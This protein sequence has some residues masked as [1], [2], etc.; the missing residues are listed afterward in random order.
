MEGGIDQLLIELCASDSELT[1]NVPYCFAALR[2]TD[3]ENLTN[4]HILQAVLGIVSI[5]KKNDV[6]IIV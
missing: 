4:S 2:I 1:K 5:A 3:K 6:K